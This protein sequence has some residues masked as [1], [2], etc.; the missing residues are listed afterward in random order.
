MTEDEKDLLIRC[1]NGDPYAQAD[2]VARYSDLVYC[3]VLRT[4]R[5]K[6]TGWQTQDVEDL[7][8]TVFFRLLERQ[9]KRLRQF[10]GRNGCS[11][12]SWVRMIAVRTVIDH[13]R[14]RTDALAH[15]GALD[16]ASLLLNLPGDLVDPVGLL[17]RAQQLDKVRQGLRSLAPRDRL[18]IKLH[19]FK[20]LSIQEVAEVLGVSENNAYTIKHRALKRLKAAL[21][22]TGKET[23]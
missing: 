17:D 12:H 13:S 16:A 5:A 15:S 14:S 6:S 1:F 10:R 22:Q 21:Q 9:C 11:L 19:C 4:L 18:F 3:T 23:E 20:E 7:Y 8:Q 2:F